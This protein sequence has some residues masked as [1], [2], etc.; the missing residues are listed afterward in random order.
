MEK[1]GLVSLEK[2]LR[3]IIEKKMV[4]VPIIICFTLASVVVAFLL[5]KTYE[6]TTLVQTRSGNKV[7]V[8]GAA[9]A[10]AALGM[11]GGTVSSSTT[12]Y[13]ELMK[14][15]AVLNPVIENLDIPNM[16][17]EKMTADGFAKSNVD[18]QNTKGTNLIVV[19]GKAATPKEAQEISQGVVDNFLLLMTN[20]N[21][22]TQSLMVKFLNERI[23]E[24]KKDSDDSAQKLEDFSKEKKV[25]GPI[26]QTSADL[27]QMAAFDKTIGDLE[28]QKKGAQAQLDSV[29]AQLNLQ[30]TNLTTYNVSDNS[31][32]QSLREKIVSK[33][34]ELVGLQQKYQDKHPSVIAAQQE[35]DQLKNSLENEVSTAVAAGTATMNPLQAELVKTKALSATNIAVASASEAAVKNLQDKSDSKMSQFSENVLEYTKLQR[36]ATMK[37]EIYLNL[38][39][40]CEQAKIQQAMESMDIQVVDDADLPKM[41]TA[42]KKTL[43]AV[44]GLILGCLVSFGY[45][46]YS[47][48]NA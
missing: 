7:D 42:P 3:D 6:S 11:G 29:S 15:R 25:Y 26:D 38:V 44:I 48:K 4:V 35:L 17:K 18:I 16:Q 22:Q 32:V 30:N 34:V 45:I 20:M 21:Q 14:S 13:I 10:M 12:A 19:K 28:V 5:P 39:K 23:V 43:I 36:D 1:E 41:P 33:E 37:N 46:L 31:T 27:K 9:V 40:Q 2:I 47:S 24:A 8:S